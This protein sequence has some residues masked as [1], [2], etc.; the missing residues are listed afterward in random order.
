LTEL[1]RA[2]CLALASGALSAAD[3]IF[4]TMVGTPS[5]VIVWGESV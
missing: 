5:F 3:L 4:L 1:A 2:L